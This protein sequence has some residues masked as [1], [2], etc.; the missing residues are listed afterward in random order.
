MS[1]PSAQQKK[2]IDYEGPRLVVVAAPGTGKTRTIVERM[3]RLLA[4]G[5]TGKVSFITFMRASRRDTCAKVEKALSP[6]VLLDDEGLPR[7]STLH[8][9]A[10]SLVHRYAAVIGRDPDFS[11]LIESKGEKKLVL[12]EVASDL[13]LVVDL[14]QLAADICCLRSTDAWPPNCC[15]SAS[16]RGEVL[17]HFESLLSF[18]NTFDLEGLI[19]AARKILSAPGVDVPPLYLQVDEYQDLN[20]AD[21]R[22]VQAAAIHPASR[23]VV[24]GDDAQSIYHFRHANYD[25]LRELWNSALWEH[26]SFLECYRLPNHIRIAAQRLVQ[27]AGYLGA[28]LAPCKDDGRKILALQCTNSDIQ[29]GAIAKKIRETKASGSTVGWVDLPSTHQ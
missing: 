17:S 16:R 12:E 1:F 8:T 2:V 21:Q 6:A 20:P 26:V 18:Y 27:Q 28:N 22:L 4:Q 23:V 3:I 25:G 9:Y 24:V 11:V 14:G 19:I 7:T 15:I 5:P 10:K 13:N 29:I